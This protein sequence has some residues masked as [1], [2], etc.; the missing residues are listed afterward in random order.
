M[1]A[2][3]QREISLEKQEAKLVGQRDEIGLLQ[4]KSM[5]RMDE[6]I[7]QQEDWGEE[8]QRQQSEINATKV[9]LSERY[10]CNCFAM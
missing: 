2:I 6:L 7:T 1:E 10:C 8:C 9:C 5:Q 3:R 4:K